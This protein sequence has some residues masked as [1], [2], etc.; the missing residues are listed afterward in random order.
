MTKSFAVMG[1]G[2]QGFCNCMHLSQRGAKKIYMI[3]PAKN[4]GGVMNSKGWRFL[5]RQWCSY[6]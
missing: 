5:C 1:S 3:D 4:F 6:V 2:F